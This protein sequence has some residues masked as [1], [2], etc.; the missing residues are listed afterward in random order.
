MY[1]PPV[2]LLPVPLSEPRK[3][4]PTLKSELTIVGSLA[5]AMIDCWMPPHFVA[6]GS[7]RCVAWLQLALLS[8]TISTFGR[9]CANAG[10]AR[11][12]AVSSFTGSNT[13]Q[14]SCGRT[15]SAAARMR[16]QVLAICM[17]VTFFLC[18]LLAY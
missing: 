17:S 18:F 1:E 7:G 11:K 2:L 6:H 5:M 14:A 3:A 15:Q 8:I 16:R 13:G 12:M 4:R 9:T 10:L